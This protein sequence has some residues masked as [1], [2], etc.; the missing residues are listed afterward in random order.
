MAKAGVVHKRGTWRGDEDVHEMTVFAPNYEMTISPLVYPD[1]S[2][3]R[4]SRDDTD[5]PEEFDTYDH[6]VGRQDG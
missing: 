6:F 4:Q 2:P 5:E 3:M 1:E